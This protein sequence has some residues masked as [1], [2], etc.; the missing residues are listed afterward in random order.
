MQPLVTAR[1][2]SSDLL[3]VAAVATGSTRPIAVLPCV[4]MPAGLSEC[5]LSVTLSAEQF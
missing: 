3:A 2:G 4:K 5:E 1:I